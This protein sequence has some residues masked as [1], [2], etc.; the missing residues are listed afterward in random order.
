MEKRMPRKRTKPR[1]LTSTPIKISDRNRVSTLS[2]QT[3]QYQFVLLHIAV[4]LLE[5]E[6]K[7]NPSILGRY[8][9]AQTA[10]AQI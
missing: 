5:E 6:L 8:F 3:G 7:K 4:D 9:E 1:D 2:A 10:E